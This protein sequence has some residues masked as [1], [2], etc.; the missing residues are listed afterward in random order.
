MTEP[1]PALSSSGIPEAAVG[2]LAAGLL[3][4]ACGTRGSLQLES[5]RDLA[6]SLG[7]E[8]EALKNGPA[9]LD[10]LA[11]VAACS[12]DLAS[13][14]AC[15]LPHVASDNVPEA[16][17]ATHLASGAARALVAGVEAAA[18]ELETSRGEYLLREARGAAW[19]AGLA[20]RQ[21]DESLEARAPKA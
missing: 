2:S 5:V 12:A 13:L 20:A 14:A 6:R 11:N 19:R 17:A 8:F 18:G 1:S 16:A 15:N 7:W 9:T 21:V 10:A 4:D 3:V